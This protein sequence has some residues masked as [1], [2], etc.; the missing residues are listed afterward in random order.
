[1]LN[2]KDLHQ[3]QRDIANF[4]LKKPGAFVI[5]EM[6]LGKTVSTLTAIN[7][8]QKEKGF[9]SALVLAPLRVVY[10]SWPDE[11]KKW[12]QLK[13]IK[14]HIIHGKGKTPHLP[15]VPFYFSNYE[16]LPYII[17][18]KLH[19]PCDILVIDESSMVKNH[20][21]KRFK[22]LKKIAKC[23]KKII[24]LTGTPSPSGY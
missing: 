15:K 22:M 2:I 24:L 14:Y 17:D 19:K 16:S 18:K 7:Y 6:G 1:M 13:G 8:L 21:T 20:K 23:F 9:K 3:Y 10:N 4:I 11:V 12:E 5:A